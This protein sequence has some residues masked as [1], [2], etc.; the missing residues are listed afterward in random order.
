MRSVLRAAAVS[1]AVLLGTGGCNSPL[2][3]GLFTLEGQWRGRG[4]PYELA[5]TLEQDEEN[6]VRGEG[7]LR[8]LRAVPATGTTPADTVVESRAN[9]DVRG[10]WRYPD[11]RLTLSADDYADIEMA[12]TF[13]NS[14]TVNVTLRGS[15]FNGAQIRLIRTAR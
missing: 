3:P 15:G 9:V 1:L 12:G 6:A 8:G 14:D 13:A 10:R 4:F 2:A 5:L 11:F 7:E